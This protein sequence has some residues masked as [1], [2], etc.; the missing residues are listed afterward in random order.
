VSI[1]VGVAL[2]VGAFA[3]VVYPLVASR[4]GGGSL[5]GSVTTASREV[6][7]EEIEAAIRSYRARES[8]GVTCQACGA[9][10]EP[11]AVFCSSCGRRLDATGSS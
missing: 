4:R 10:P 5:R 3:Y 6:S 7:D 2:A 1:W 9:R 8:H 11:D